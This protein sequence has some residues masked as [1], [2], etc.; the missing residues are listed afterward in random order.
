MLNS[1]IENKAMAFA[2]KNKKVI[3]RKYTSLDIYPKD[4]KP[5]S[6]FMAGSPGA[7]KTE[8]SKRFLEDYDG[9]NVIRI[10][11]D[12]LRKEFKDYSGDNSHLFQGAV[13]TLANSIH[14]LAL[15]QDQ[16]FL[17][18]GTFSNYDQAKLNIERSLKRGRKVEVVYI[19]QN[20]ILAWEFVQ[21]REKKEGRR[22]RKEDF[23]RQ[24]F[25]A[26]YVVN[27]IKKEFRANIT[28]SLVV[29]DVNAKNERTEQNIDNIDNF[30]HKK[31][32]RDSLDQ[33][34]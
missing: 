4:E 3:A 28:L 13:S 32:S 21:E 20:P 7:G 12:D 33:M 14:D 30:I 25:D 24:F 16:N 15:K 8:F 10:D 23:I 29:K 31:Y 26:Q 34:I 22:I 1:E 11:S 27:S 6:I 18:D 2:N 9:R 19:Y 5:V 17:F